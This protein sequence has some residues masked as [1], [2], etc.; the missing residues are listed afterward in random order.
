M[1]NRKKISYSADKNNRNQSETKNK[2]WI[3]FLTVLK[4]IALI[5]CILALVM[6]AVSIFA[7]ILSAATIKFAIAAVVLFFV[8][9]MSKLLVSCLSNKKPKENESP[10]PKQIYM[11]LETKENQNEFNINNLVNNE[12]NINQIGE[13]EKNNVSSI[14]G[15]LG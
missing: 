11:N 10:Y 2:G 9:V 12:S 6:T 3:K 15:S 7:E 8:F 14:E 1:F 4:W 5:G 13:Q